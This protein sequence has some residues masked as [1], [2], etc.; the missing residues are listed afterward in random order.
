MYN[1][2]SS[3]KLNIFWLYFHRYIRLTPALAAA[4]LMCTSLLRLFD[5]GPLWNVYMSA[6][7][8]P[9]ND[10]WWSALIYLQNYINPGEIVN[11]NSQSSS[12]KLLRNYYFGFSVWVIHGICLSICNCMCYHRWFSIQYGS[13]D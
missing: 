10:Y 12:S 11:I 9:C 5:T 13:G 6:A 7:D 1:L 3:G 8:K 4:I 2:Y